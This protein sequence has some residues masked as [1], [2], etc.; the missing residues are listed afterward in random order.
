MKT[1][2]WSRSERLW[3]LFLTFQTSWSLFS[4]HSQESFPVPSE[5]LSGYHIC[6]CV[7]VSSQQ[8][9]DTHTKAMWMFKAS[10]ITERIIFKSF[11][12]SSL[13]LCQ[14]LNPLASAS[15]RKWCNSSACSQ[16]VGFI[17]PP[18]TWPVFTPP[19]ASRTSCTR[20]D[21]TSTCR[22]RRRAA[23]AFAPAPSRRAPTPAAGSAPASWTCGTDME[24]KWAE[25]KIVKR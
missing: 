8:C 13:K 10:V 6:V 25:T 14:R 20:G 16:C 18:D 2:S 3:N 7:C 21:S 11:S 15:D 23:A 17:P 5:D 1:D 22:E 4:T 12:S 19:T 24:D 9:A